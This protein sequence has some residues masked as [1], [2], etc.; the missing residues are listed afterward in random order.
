LLNA[1]KSFEAAA[2]LGSFRDASEELNVS[3]SA[4]SHQIKNLERSLGLALFIRTA[5]SVELTAAGKAYFPVV[6]DAFDRIH[7]GTRMLLSPHD[8]N[9][10]T[11]QIYSTFTVR[12]LMSRLQKFQDQYPDIQVRVNT[13]QMNVDFSQQGID[14]G[15]I[16]GQ[17]RHDDIHYEYMFSPRLMVVCSPKYLEKCTKDGPSLSAPA[18]LSAHPI[19]QVYPSEKDWQIW[20]GENNVKNVD[21]DTG[22]RFDS[23]D[24]AL[25]MAARGQGIALA[26]QPYVTED[27]ELGKLVD[28]FPDNHVRTIGH[29]YLVYPKERHSVEKIQT[30]RNWLQN[31]IRADPEIMPLIEPRQFATL[32]RVET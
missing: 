23:Y 21:P 24:H 16:I 15:I 27:F 12:W 22:L 9:I 19:L 1:L 31:E 5:R 7:E 26:M 2:R 3:Q 28:I 10:L 13:A 4:V 32:T 6:K 14:L 30:F 18:D 11:I 8:K 20:L 17:R 25:K 29:W